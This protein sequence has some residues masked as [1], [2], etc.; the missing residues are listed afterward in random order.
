MALSEDHGRAHRR[1]AG[2]CPTDPAC[3]RKDTA[4]VTT[5]F[6]PETLDIPL[7]DAREATVRIGFGGG[8]LTVGPAAPGTLLRA[9]SRAVSSGDE[10]LRATSSST[11]PCRTARAL[12]PLHWDV[13]PDNGGPRR[14]SSGDQSNRSAVDLDLRCRSGGST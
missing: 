5:T 3:L 4:V 8:E 13:P 11:R 1:H 7:G 10:S 6:P 14:A 2:G 12:R 9:R